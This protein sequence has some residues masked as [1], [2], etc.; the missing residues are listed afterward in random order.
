MS[1]R[2]VGV[3]L[4]VDT[5][6][7]DEDLD[8]LKK[9]LSCIKGVYA[10]SGGLLK[11]FFKFQTSSLKLHLHQWKSVHLDGDIITVFVESPHRDL[12]GDL[13]LVLA[14]VDLIDQ[15]YGTVFT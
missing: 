14:P 7:D 8:K 11:G 2:T 15:F 4:G 3:V 1:Q 13:K 10:I 6:A 9:P 12:L 5:I